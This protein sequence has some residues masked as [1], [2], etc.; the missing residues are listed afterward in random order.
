MR[1]DFN[2]CASFFIGGKLCH[3]YVFFILYFIFGLF[4]ISYLYP[5]IN[6]VSI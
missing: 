5:E 2:G 4:I 1:H 6:L 3:E